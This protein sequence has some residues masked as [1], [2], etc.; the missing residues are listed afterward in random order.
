MNKVDQGHWSL[1][2]EPNVGQA[3]FKMS[4]T[5]TALN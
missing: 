1:N 3:P 4:F 2:N 5:A